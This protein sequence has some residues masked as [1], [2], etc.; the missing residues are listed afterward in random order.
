MTALPQQFTEKMEGLLGDEYRDYLH[1]LEQPTVS[2]LRVNRSK[3]SPEEFSSRIPFDLNPVPWCP[4]GYYIENASVRPSSH[5]FY[6]CGLYYLQEPSAMVPASFLPV[7]PGDRVLDLC[8][9]PGGKSTQLAQNIQESG[10]LVSNDVSASRSKALLKNIELFGLKNTV[11]TCETPARLS[12]VFPEY[13][14]KILVDA[15]CSG[16]GMF[17]R[18]DRMIRAWLEHGPGYFAPIQKS[19]VKE[20]LTMLKPGGML[21]Y[22][23]CTFDPSEDEEVIDYMLEICPSLHIVPTPVFAGFV[24]G[25]P[26]YAGHDPEGIKNAVRLFPHRVRGDGHF[27]ALLQKEGT[28]SENPEAADG[29]VVIEQKMGNGKARKTVRIEL[30]AMF[31]EPPALRYKRSGLLLGE[32]RNG[33]LIPSQA[34][35]MTLKAG[36]YSPALDLSLEDERTGRYL[37]GESLS[38]CDHD[39]LPERG[40]VLIMIDGFPAGWGT[41]AG[42]RI[43]N[44]LL[45]GWRMMS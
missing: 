21:L 6:S 11:V 9:A 38:V 17:R 28:G 36:R 8:A 32:I 24:Q 42:K 37:K 26:Q 10:L 2:G 14:D 35:A 41:I 7:E 30:P 40:A 29:P 33:R 15:P 19:I 34:Y 3:I 31:T 22:S 20:A 12:E 4:D 16:E 44:K 39:H 27:A 13:F 25:L 45:P 23:T 5:P 43:K 18:G 1:A